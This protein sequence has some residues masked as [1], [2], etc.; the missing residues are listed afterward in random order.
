MHILRLKLILQDYLFFATTERGKVFETGRFIH[1]YALTYALGMACSDYFNPISQAHY[2]Q[3]LEPLNQRGIYVTPG[4][5]IKGEYALH[6]FNTLPETYNMV[7]EQSVGY[8]EWGFI[9]VL[10]P[11]SCFYAYLISQSEQPKIPSFIRLGKFM[12]KTLV[13]AEA[14]EHITMP[15]TET[16]HIAESLLNVRDLAQLPTQYDL[17]ANALPTRLLYNAHFPKTRGITAI[18]PN[19]LSQNKAE[20]EVWLPYPMQYLI[21]C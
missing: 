18:F 15:S 17:I 4:Q 14:P 2:K 7:K 11:G 21:A 6:Q 20:K 19:G 16:D 8:P 10:K 13:V 5:C 9:K 12:S 3:D 1:N